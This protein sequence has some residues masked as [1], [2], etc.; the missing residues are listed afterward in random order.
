[1]FVWTLTFTNAWSLG[2]Q[3]FV[4]RLHQ[5]TETDFLRR[6]TNRGPPSSCFNHQGLIF[7][8]FTTVVRS[9]RSSSCWPCPHW[10]TLR[11]REE[12][13]DW[14]IKSSS[15][16]LVSYWF[17]IK[18]IIVSLAVSNSFSRNSVLLQ[19]GERSTHQSAK[20]NNGFEANSITLLY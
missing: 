6:Q 17:I 3:M 11:V 12:S 14:D 20:F 15:P 5:E 1:M 19:D 7:T 16:Y 13:R 8:S 18:S 10:L 4:L 2:M 9:P